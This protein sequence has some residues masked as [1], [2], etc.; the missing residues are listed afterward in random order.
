VRPGTPIA[1]DRHEMRYEPACQHQP[2]CPGASAPDRAAARVLACHPGQGWSL[3]CNGVVLFDDAGLLVP[4]A[5]TTPGR[6]P[7]LPRAA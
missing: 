5:G 7:V 4:A 1:C 6:A 2:R 3:L